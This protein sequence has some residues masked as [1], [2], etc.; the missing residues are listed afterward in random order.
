MKFSLILATVGRSDEV[1]RLLASLDAQDYRNFELIVVDQNKDDRLLPILASYREKFSIRHVRSVAHGASRARNV[2]L[3]LAD[4]DV[5]SF[6]DD[7]CWYPPGLLQKVVTVLDSHPELDG[8]TGRFTD[9]DGRTEGRWLESSMLLNRYNV[10]RG[11]IEFS[12][13]LHRRVV[14]AVGPFNELLGVGAGTV[15][16]AAEGTDYLLRS[17]RHGFKLKF[18]VDLT[19]HHPVKTTDFDAVACSRQKKYET[20]IGHVMRIN[21]YPL[22]YFPATCLR[23]CVGILLAV[24]K[25]DFPKARFKYVSVLARM[26]GWRG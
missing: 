18:L 12:I 2:G 1:A 17:L 22:W 6:P 10:W 26:Q 9:G 25:G 14:D 15:W 11:A 4:G 21:D 7:D 8:I 20:G 13:F 24:A 23:T 19:L 16:G 5:I 3:G